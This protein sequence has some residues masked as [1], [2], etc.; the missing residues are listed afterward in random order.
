MNIELKKNHLSYKYRQRSNAR[1]VS[2]SMNRVHN[3]EMMIVLIVTSF[4]IVVM[5]EMIV[6]MIVQ[7]IVLI[8]MNV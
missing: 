5:N 6:Q 2:T 7:M 1:N 3:V 8:I 4:L